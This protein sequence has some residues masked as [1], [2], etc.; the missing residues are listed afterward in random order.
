VGAVG[1]A[2]HHSL[3]AFGE[4]APKVIGRDAAVFPSQTDDEVAKRKRP[5]GI[6]VEE[7]KGRALGAF[8]HEMDE[9]VPEAVSDPVGDREVVALERV[10]VAYAREVEGAV[11]VLHVWNGL[12]LPL[13]SQHH[14]GDA[15]TDA[16]HRK[17]ISA[18]KEVC[19]HGF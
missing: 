14:G 2:V 9:G 12:L 8:I 3:R 11:F 5:G 4:P 6:A 17:A 10:D 13:E 19:L 15:T 16:E 18:V 1:Q 7:E